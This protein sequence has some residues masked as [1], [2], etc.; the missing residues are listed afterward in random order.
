MDFVD[1]K[2]SRLTKEYLL[3]S[4]GEFDFETIFHL[5]LTKR[6]IQRMTGLEVCKKYYFNTCFL[7]NTDL[8]FLRPLKFEIL[9]LHLFVS[10]VRLDLSRNSVIR[11]EAL[12]TLPKLRNILHTQ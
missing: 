5:E 8:K 1:K 11:I 7:I 2:C 12:E 10:L 4:A 6:D 3:L 9:C